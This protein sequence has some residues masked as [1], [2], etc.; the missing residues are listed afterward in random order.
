MQGLCGKQ[1][2]SIVC[3]LSVCAVHV[4]LHRMVR[5]PRRVRRLIA[6]G[7]RPVV[8]VYA[9]AVWYA[10][11]NLCF[12]CRISRAFLCHNCFL[13]CR[14]WY[15]V[16]FPPNVHFVPFVIYMR[17]RFLQKINI[18]QVTQ[19]KINM[20]CVEFQELSNGALTCQL[21]VCGTLFFSRQ[22]CIFGF[23]TKKICEK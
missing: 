2:S 8:S 23:F 12:L 3:V 15:R 4:L 20:F 5:R 6:A 17:A 1:P 19:A 9:L 21:I 16:F 22:M 7:V 11:Q 10:G 18:P 13:S 14:V